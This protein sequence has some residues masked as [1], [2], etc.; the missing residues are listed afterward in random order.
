M[1]KP[2]HEFRIPL[3]PKYGSLYLRVTIFESKKDMYAYC[4][5]HCSAISGEFKSDFKAIV[6]S[7]TKINYGKSKRGRTSPE[8]GH[9]HFTRRNLTMEIISHEAGHAALTWFRRLYRHKGDLED[10]RFEEALC[11]A[12]GYIAKEIVRRTR[13][14]T[15]ER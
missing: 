14:V 10:M 7:Y 4:Q 2:V 3:Y 15:I 12:L 5:K 6:H 13:K 11:Y 8:F 9:A 1:V